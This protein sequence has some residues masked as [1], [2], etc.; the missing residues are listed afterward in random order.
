MEIFIHTVE[1]IILGIFVFLCYWPTDAF[2]EFSRRGPLRDTSKPDLKR[3]FRKFGIFVIFL[4][5]V[6][7][8]QLY[9]ILTGG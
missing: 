2:L 1:V 3:S 7:V 6:N 5:A 4:E 8:L 9:L